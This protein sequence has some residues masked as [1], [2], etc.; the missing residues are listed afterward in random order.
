MTKL[1]DA[2][3]AKARQKGFAEALLLLLYGRGDLAPRFGTFADFLVD[4]GAGRWTTV[5]YFLF[6]KEP[7]G[8]VLVKPKL[9]QRFAD[10]VGE[11]IN[12]RM[13][14]NWHTYHNCLNLAIRLKSML[15]DLRPRDLMDVQSFMWFTGR[16]R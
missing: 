6:M 4:A 15:S 16:E 13:E 1:A 12:Y 2:L 5:T 10:V 3:K 11:E 9:F 8:H 14:P 7:G